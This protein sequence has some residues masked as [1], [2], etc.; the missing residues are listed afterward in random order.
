MEGVR[1]KDRGLTGEVGVKV[2]RNEVRLGQHL[3]VWTAT[4]KS[5]TV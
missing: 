4:A 2:V 5:H 1:K 3:Y